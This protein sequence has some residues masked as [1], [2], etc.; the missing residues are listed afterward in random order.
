MTPR[1]VIIDKGIPYPPELA[2]YRM[3]RKWPWDEVE[4][5]DSIL[6]KDVKEAKSARNS[7]VKHQRTKHSRINPAWRVFMKRLEDGTYRLWV[8][9]PQVDN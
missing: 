2:P 3:P 6:C 5:G 1:K 8:Y 7:F 9:D 4:L